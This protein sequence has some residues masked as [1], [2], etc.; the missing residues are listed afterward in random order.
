MNQDFLVDVVDS[1]GY[2]GIEQFLGDNPGAVE[3]LLEFISA[4]FLGIGEEE[5]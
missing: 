4:N 2:Q 3:L 5:D 1:L